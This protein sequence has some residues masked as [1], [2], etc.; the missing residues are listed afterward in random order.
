MTPYFFE[1]AAQ[2]SNIEWDIEERCICVLFYQEYNGQSKYLFLS[3]NLSSSEILATRLPT[4]TWLLES[5]SILS[6]KIHFL[7]EASILNLDGSIRNIQ[8]KDVYWNTY[9]CFH[10]TKSSFGSIQHPSDSLFQT[11]RFWNNFSIGEDITRKH[12]K[13]HDAYI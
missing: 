2:R 6:H 11:I 5:M 4:A 10:F 3:T 12:S 13:I 9:M 1:F 7:K 8:Y